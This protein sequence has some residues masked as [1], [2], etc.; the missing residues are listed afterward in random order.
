MGSWTALA[1]ECARAARAALQLDPAVSPVAVVLGS[2]LGAFGD[3]L[4]GARSVSFAD[5][6]GLP[7]ATV[8]GHKGRLAS[9]GLAGGPVLAQPG[10]PHGAG[11]HDAANVAVPAAG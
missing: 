6:P 9:G 3:Q 2:G 10:R 1:L 11:G 5:L 7:R 4:V 8:L